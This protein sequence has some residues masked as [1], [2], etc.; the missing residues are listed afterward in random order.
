MTFLIKNK[1][2]FL[3]KKRKASFYNIFVLDKVYASRMPTAIVVLSCHP[4]S[5]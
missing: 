4:A 2:R 3:N 5:K 1:R